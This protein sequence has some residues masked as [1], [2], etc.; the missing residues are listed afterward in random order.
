MYV[1]VLFRCKVGVINNKWFISGRSLRSLAE[2]RFEKQSFKIEYIF[3]IVISRMESCRIEEELNF[4]KQLDCLSESSEIKEYFKSRNMLDFVNTY[5]RLDRDLRDTLSGLD[6]VQLCKDLRD[7]MSMKLD[8]QSRNM[9]RRLQEQV[10]NLDTQS[11][12][13]ERRLD[14]QS[15]NVERKIEEQFRSSNVEKEKSFSVD[16]ENKLG[17][18][19]QNDMRISKI[20]DTLVTLHNNF[21]SNSSKKGEMAE[22]ML[23]RNLLAAFPDSDVQNTSQIKDACDIQIKRDNR[24]DILIDSKHFES[25]NVPKRDLDK[26]YDNCTSNNACGIIANAYGGIC[27]KKNLEIDI[28]DRRVYVYLSNHQFDTTNFELATTII[29]NMYELM[30]DKKTQNIEVDAQVYQRM[31]I[32]YNHFLLNFN[33]HLETLK[34]T[35]TSMSKLCFIQIDHFFKRTKFEVEAKPFNC[36]LCGTGLGSE[37]AY[38]KHMKDKHQ[39]VSNAKR[40]RKV[41]EEEEDEELTLSDLDLE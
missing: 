26:F 6:V 9:E 25:C 7:N 12:N 19:L 35:M 3:I 17:V 41:K 18:C 5:M 28:Q 16:L 1:R 10:V 39:V 13:L 32:E 2:R 33:E 27:G 8:E 31:K 38:K 29:Y 4:N 15:R 23:F 22:N 20:H 21:T 36:H 37:K 34:Q 30:K 24:P 14:D 40:G 11:R